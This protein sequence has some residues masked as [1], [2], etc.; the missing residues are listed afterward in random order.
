M[1][2]LLRIFLVFTIAL[3]YDIFLFAQETDDQAAEMQIWTEYMTPGPMH[4]ML[5]N[6]VGDWK[7][8]SKYW[9]G[10]SGEPMTYEG[11]AK[12]EMILGGRY[13]K[14]IHSAVV[15]GMPME[16]ISL[17]GY[18]NTAHEFTSVWID[19]L[20]TGTAVAKG[21]YDQ[22]SNSIAMIGTMIDPMAKGEVNFTQ[23]MKFFDDNHFTF[24]IYLIS[25]DK[26]F[27]SMEIEF[28]R[29]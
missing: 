12:T 10:P 9:T 22:E 28:V 25:E 26:E 29:Q 4:N 5:A 27:K 6:Q 7:T 8:I 21:K 24:E 20:G 11:L 13:Q 19:N 3:S 23:K 15:M 14:S 17:L 2:K 1:L 16:G 18:D